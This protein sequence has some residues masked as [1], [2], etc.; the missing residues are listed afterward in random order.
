[1][2][3][4]IRRL[5]FDDP[6]RSYE[7]D[8]VAITNTKNGNVAIVLDDVILPLTPKVAIKV[9]QSLIKAGRHQQERKNREKRK[10]NA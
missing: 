3:K 9:G 6:K 7:K 1:M 8:R 10:Q 4:Y 2:L 5:F